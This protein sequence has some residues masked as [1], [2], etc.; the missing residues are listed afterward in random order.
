MVRL[1]DLESCA[2]TDSLGAGCQSYIEG[3]GV[4][5]MVKMKLRLAA[6][7]LL[8]TFA[9]TFGVLG[10]S[11]PKTEST[12]GALKNDQKVVQSEGNEASEG[13]EVK[14][15]EGKKE[16]TDVKEAPK[17]L[18][19]KNIK[20]ELQG[21]SFDI[22]ATYGD[23]PKLT[24]QPK[25]LKLANDVI[26][27]EIDGTLTK[28]EVGDLKQIVSKKHRRKHADRQS[29]DQ[30]DRKP[31]DLLGPHIIKDQGADE[32]CQVRV[33][34]RRPSSIEAVANRHAIRRI[35][36][37]LLSYPLKHQN[38]GVDTHAHRQNQPR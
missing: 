1:S 34:N 21:V 27:H 28:A 26:E 11:Q 36:F 2:I 10:C 22:T 24:I 38:I 29:N 37:L 23:K 13:K 35:L 4:G 20:L 19:P 15:K 18:E 31:L 25:G 30:R 9:L 7:A 32:R 33:E 6:L 12:E 14:E 5:N 17:A 16:E 8:S 3:H